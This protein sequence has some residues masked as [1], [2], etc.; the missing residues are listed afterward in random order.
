MVIYLRESKMALHIT[1]TF[2]FETPQLGTLIE[3]QATKKKNKNSGLVIEI[4]A[5]HVGATKNSN[6]Y[7]EAALSEGVSTWTAPFQKPIIINH[8]IYTDAL[9]RVIGAKMESS[10]DGVPFIN[11]QAAIT[12]P[13][14]IE[15]VISKRYLTGSIGASAESAVCSICGVDWAKGS[16]SAGLPCKHRFGNE[17]DGKTAYRILGGLNFIEYSF[18]NAPS[19]QKSMIQNVE[20]SYESFDYQP[21]FYELNW[22]TNSIMEMVLEEES[23]AEK[24]IKVS[25][26]TFLG[27]KGAYFAADSY[28]K[29]SNV[30]F[31]DTNTTNNLE[32]TNI[33]EQDMSEETTNVNDTSDVIN[34]EEEDILNVIEESENSADENEE[35]SVDEEEES[36]SEDEQSEADEADVDSEESD[37]SAEESE[38]SEEDTDESV[39]EDLTEEDESAE[40]EDSTEESEEDSENEESQEDTEDELAEESSDES[41]V[42]E[43]LDEIASLKTRVE[44]LTKALHHSLV[45]RVVDAK[46]ARNIVKESDRVAAIEEHSA[47]KASSI[48]D[49]LKDLS[50]IPMQANFEQK[51]TESFNPKTVSTESSSNVEFDDEEE[52]EESEVS[53]EDTIVQKFSNVLLGK[54]ELH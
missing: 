50:A 39:E 2:Q 5:I 29:S 20:V 9:G 18:V 37:E 24:E 4:A 35:V 40:E 25:E 42:S 23:V 33:G 12:D 8:D 46:I 21:R 7:S 17:Y 1:E 27:L 11:I 28:T 51:L 49:S 54:T 48:M 22:E 36:D 15:K 26:S 52:V 47:R 34:E 38:E 45:E 13:A 10:E 41:Q 19:D 53:V 44:K 3:E 14:G 16:E 6:Y 30:K 31:I 32:L 43:L